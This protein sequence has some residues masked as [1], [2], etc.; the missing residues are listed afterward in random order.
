M[1]TAIDQSVEWRG[2]WLLL[3]RRRAV[4]GSKT[5]FIESAM[6]DAEKTSTLETYRREPC[7][8]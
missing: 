3:V 8:T 5:I 1:A 2:L 7:K 6:P 4:T